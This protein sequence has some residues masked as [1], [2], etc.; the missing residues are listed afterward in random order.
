M[1]TKTTKKARMYERIQ[2]HG[3][4]LIAAFPGSPLAGDPVMLCKRLRMIEACENRRACMECNGVVEYDED[5]NDAALRRVQALLGMSDE[6]AVQTGL[7]INRDPRGYALKFDDEWTRGYNAHAEKH[8]YTDLGGY[9]I[10]AP[11]L[12]DD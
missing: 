12:T 10:L 6:M 1:T 7:F 4:S 3:E 5:A 2:R 9:G 8:I 11:D